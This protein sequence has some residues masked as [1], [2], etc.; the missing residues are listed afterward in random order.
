MLSLANNDAHSDQQWLLKACSKEIGAHRVIFLIVLCPLLGYWLPS[1]MFNVGLAVGIGAW[2][3][4]TNQDAAGDHWIGIAG[5]AAFV[6]PIGPLAVGVL[7]ERIR[8]ALEDRGASGGM[9]LPPAQEAML[10]HRVAGIWGRLS[11]SA[12]RTLPRVICQPNFRVL[13]HAYD[14]GREQAIEVSAGL[15]SR[16]VRDDELAL[17]ILRHEMAHLVYA[18]LPAIRLQSILA[19]AAVLSIDIS[20]AA[21]LA[22]ALTITV[23]T[24]VGAFPVAPTFTGIV[25]VHAAILLGT[26][27]VI[28]PLLL[29]RYAVRR[30]AGFCVALVEMRADVAAGIWGDGLTRFSRRLESD[31]TIEAPSFDDVGLAYLSPALSHFPPRERAALLADPARLATPKLRYFA[32]A[33]IAV[34]LLAFHQGQQVWDATLLAVAVAFLQGITVS[35]VLDAGRHTR[36]SAWQAM[37]LAF[38]M[39]F[40]QALPLI[41]IEGVVY[42]TQHLTAAL[43]TPGGFGKAGDADLWRD[44]VGTFQEFGRFASQA[45]GGTACLLSLAVVSGAFW[46]SP[47]LAARLRTK[48][49]RRIAIAAAFLTATSSFVVSHRFFQEGLRHALREFA[50]PWSPS[51]ADQVSAAAAPFQARISQLLYSTSDALSGAPLLGDLAWVRLAL[52]DLVG[53]AALLIFWLLTLLHRPGDDGVGEGGR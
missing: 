39:L 28:T 50:F 13:A 44:T 30:Y 35:M 12:G 19:A 8:L 25:A 18:D 40:A 2:A 27:N 49:A 34:W 45:V 10:T 52:P 32:I 15:A 14:D 6:L 24:D 7:R 31:P 48:P 5:I 46:L 51:D 4:S 26:L 17:S 36:V 41:S 43:V 9:K 33:I 1:L 20:M 3:N 38:G 29:G 37:T 53:F 47:R 16:V 22:A 42:L 23:L 21:C 11:V